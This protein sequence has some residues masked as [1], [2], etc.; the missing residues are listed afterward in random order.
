MNAADPICVL[1]LAD[2]R[3]AIPLAVTVRS[4]LE[5]LEADR[6]V[7]LTIID[8]GM[9]DA[10]KEKLADSWRTAE[11]WPRISIEWRTPDSRDATPVP[12]WGRVPKLTYERIN[13]GLYLANASRAIILDSDV[14]VRTCIGRL[15][16]TPLGG[17]IA[18]ATVDPFVPTVSSPDGLAAHSAMGLSPEAPYLNAGV[19][20]VDLQLWREQNV[21]PRAFAWVKQNWQAARCYDQDAINALLAGRWRQL[22]VRWQVQPRIARLPLTAAEGG[23][24]AWIV[25]FSG[26]LKPWLYR[27]NSSADREFFQVLDRTAWHGWRPPVTLR[28]A[29][30]GFYERRLRRL[31]YPWE[32]RALGL[33]NRFRRRKEAIKDL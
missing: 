33:L 21:G 7:H 16:D 8:G 31:L 13:V 17:A 23:G 15:W 22:D 14:L 18:A 28:S 19:M 10:T 6:S 9:R 32:V 24:D 12:A 27:G 3:Y 30:T 2:D 25:H 26:R 20:L 1:T 4:L 5:R 29:L 11:A